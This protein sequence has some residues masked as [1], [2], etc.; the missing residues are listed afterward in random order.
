[1][2]YEKFTLDSKW[3]R[4]TFLRNPEEVKD[5]S[6]YM[7]YPNMCVYTKRGVAFHMLQIC[8]K[9][10]LKPQQSGFSKLKAG[11][12]IINKWTIPDSSV[13]VRNP[14]YLVLVLFWLSQALIPAHKKAFPGKKMV[15]VL[16]NAPYHRKKGKDVP[17]FKS[18]QST[19]QNSKLTSLFA[20]LSKIVQK[21]G[22]TQ[23]WAVGQICA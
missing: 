10:K 15:L 16:D 4:P 8:T 9:A 19:C 5:W 11:V 20:K 3:M 13:G 2:G 17:F 23:I 7:P 6:L 12:T 1:M 18:F 14:I 22:F 21:I